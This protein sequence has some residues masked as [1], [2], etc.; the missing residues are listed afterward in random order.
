MKEIKFRGISVKSNDWVYGELNT[1]IKSKQTGPLIWDEVKPDSVG[2]F[3][4]L[5]DKEGIEIYSGD[6]VTTSTGKAMVIGWS[7]KFASFV[8]ERDGWA[9][10][11][12]FGEG[13]NPQDCTVIGSI[14]QN[15]ELLCG[16]CGRKESR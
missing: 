14:H 10:Q 12:F 5:K 3:T 15:P 16:S 13:M 11:H 9:F 7:E 1:Y 2:M 8:I 6:I 4:G